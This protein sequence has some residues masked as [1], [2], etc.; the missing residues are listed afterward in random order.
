[1]R[2]KLYTPQQAP[3][4]SFFF[5]LIHNLSTHFPFTYIHTSLSHYR[6]LWIYQLPIKVYEYLN[7]S[8]QAKEKLS[9]YYYYIVV[10]H[11]E[12]FTQICIQW[13]LL[14]YKFAWIHLTGYRSVNFI[15][16]HCTYSIFS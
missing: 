11:L 8:Q 4:A 6:S 3:R 9:K 2:C 12:E 16:F 7:E 14:L 1:M 15:Q 10:L 5:L 13:G